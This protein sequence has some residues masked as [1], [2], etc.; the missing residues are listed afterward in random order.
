V[1]IAAAALAALPLAA[2]VAADKKPP[3]PAAPALDG[4]ALFHEKCAMCHGPTGMGT[5]LLDR[6]VKPALLEERKDLTV[7]YV[8]TAARTGIGN[9]PPIPRGEASDAQLGA[10]AKYLAAPAAPAKKGKK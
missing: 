2:A 6:R 10:I 7:D 3:A 9:M 8:I 5:G 1:L 4:K